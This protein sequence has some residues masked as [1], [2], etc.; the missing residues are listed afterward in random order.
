MVIPK[1]PVVFPSKE[2][3]RKL[4]ESDFRPIAEKCAS[5]QFL[6]DNLEKKFREGESL[7]RMFPSKLSVLRQV[8][9]PFEGGVDGG[10]CQ[11]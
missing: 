3:R 6:K 4:D 9:R 5:A 1:T 11:T 10:Y 2:R 8:W 7:G